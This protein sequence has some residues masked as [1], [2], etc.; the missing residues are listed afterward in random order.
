MCATNYRV[1][2]FPCFSSVIFIFGQKVSIIVL[3]GGSFET[4]DDV[5]IFYI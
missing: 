4:V 1:E 3:F 5:A 2:D